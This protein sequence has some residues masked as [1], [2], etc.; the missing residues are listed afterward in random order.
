MSLPIID[1]HQ[2]AAAGNLAGLKQAAA[3]ESPQALREAARQFESLFTS[4]VLKSMRA[5]SFKDPIFGSDQ[6][7]L[8]QEMYDDQVAAE[9]S[10]G[11]GLGLAD[12]LVQQLR[13]GGIGGAD[14]ATGPTPTS[15]QTAGKPV[16]A[17]NAVSAADIASA[18]SGKSTATIATSPGAGVSMGATPGASADVG[19]TIP[20]ATASPIACPSSTQQTE[21]ARALWPDAQQAARQLG[22]SPVTLLAQ[23]ALETDWGRKVPQD[24]SGSTSNNLFGIKATSGWT[25][26]AVVNSTRE[27]SGGAAGTVKAAFRAYG[28]AGD[29]FQDYVDV[30]KSNPRYLGAL[31]TGND[32][33]AFGSALQQ[34]GYAT[35]PAY[36]SK[37]TAVAGTLAHALT[38]TAAGS[39]SAPLASLKFATGRPTTDGSGTLQRR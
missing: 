25:G 3:N 1:P 26:A 13:R 2:L 36:A 35:D 12:M 30:L 6:Q 5:A 21:F 9:M 31:G 23:A 37:L 28:S 24:A 33:Q 8:Y 14:S 29:C 39:G 32:V 16:A 34:G 15:A 22:V 38:Q 4:M 10:K 17:A 7:D 19:R 11:K 18:A 27:F 20:A